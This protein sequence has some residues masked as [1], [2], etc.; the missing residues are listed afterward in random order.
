MTI[1]LD[2]ACPLARVLRSVRLHVQRICD[3]SLNVGTRVLFAFSPSLQWYATYD[4]VAHI[5]FCRAYLPICQLTNLL[6][7]TMHTLLRYAGHCRGVVVCCGISIGNYTFTECLHTRSTG[8]SVCMIQKNYRGS[9]YFQPLYLFQGILLRDCPKSAFVCV[10]MSEAT[11]VNYWQWS[12]SKCIN[13]QRT[14]AAAD[15]KQT[16]T[17]QQ[18][19]KKQHLFRTFYRPFSIYRGP[20]DASELAFF[21]PLIIFYINIFLLINWRKLCS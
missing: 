11:S 9:I 12:M 6:A 17:K 5:M 10:A 15:E 4:Y 19:K 20:D 21:L 3:S 1:H 8:F 14:S 7:T 18:Q 2:R 13:H 16:K